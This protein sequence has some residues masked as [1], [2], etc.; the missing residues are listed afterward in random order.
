M[1][2]A[3]LAAVSAAVL[4][5]AAEASAR[6]GFYL[7]IKGGT[8]NANLN[9]TEDSVVDEA[10]FDFD[11][12][13]F[14]AGSL[15]YRYSF[16]RFELE[17]THRN[18]YEV[19]ANDEEGGLKSKSYM[20]NV[21]LDFAPYYVVSPYISGG[22]G[23]TDLKLSHTTT[24]T[25]FGQAD[26]TNFTWSLGGG[27][28]VRI[29]KCLNMDLGYR[30]LDMGNVDINTPIGKVGELDVNAHESYMGLRYTF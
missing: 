1:K 4:F 16:M 28:T 27:L 20:A 26:T 23:F 9:D 7:G 11:Y 8:A 18:E 14:F 24:G 15:G 21:Y 30:Y 6:D 10:I 3:L 17:Y 2:K 22:L 12:E 25:N 13:W 5:A 19:K 29:N